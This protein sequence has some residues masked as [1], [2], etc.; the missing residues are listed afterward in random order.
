MFHIDLR[1][2]A[3][4]RIL[5]G[6]AVIGQLLTRLQDFA[7]FYTDQGIL[8]HQL[9]RELLGS[10][11]YWSLY[12][13]N[14]SPEWALFLWSLN[15]LFAIAVV[16]GCGTRFS[17]V[18][19]LILLWSLQ[20]RNV[21]VLTAGDILL[22]LLLIWM[23]LLPVNRFWSVDAWMRWCPRPHYLVENSWATTGIMLQLAAIYFFAG[24]AKLNEYWFSGEAL[25]YS[26]QLEMFASSWGRQLLNWPWPMKIATWVTLVIEIAAPVLL[27]SPWRTQYLRGF[28]M[29]L[30]WLLHASVWLTMS[31]GWFSPVAMIAWLIFVP[32]ELWGRLGL[33][34]SFSRLE[35]PAGGVKNNKFVD[36][37]G[38]LLILHLMLLNSTAAL[39]KTGLIAVYHQFSVATMTIQEFR[40][41]AQPP[42]YSP[43]MEYRA[44][45]VNGNRVDLFSK[46]FR[47]AQ[48]PPARLGFSELKHHAWRRYH[49][50]LIP[51]PETPIASGGQPLVDRARSQLLQYHVD[52]WNE[53]HDDAEQ[54]QNAELY[55]WIRP[56]TAARTNQPAEPQFWARY[57]RH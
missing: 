46:R 6:I 50:S 21:Y 48:A 49:A 57:Q 4:L 1:S 32:T 10:S 33:E 3:L 16:C 27:F 12:W 26:M 34:L 17:L 28:L 54:V 7:A 55:C 5:V 29:G 9:A 20:V 35:M 51:L 38:F 56:L 36:G 40:M 19:C 11:S 44:E 30:F 22:R 2:L 53:Q 13:L 47:A 23:V 18:A 24:I 52:R 42:L 39:S 45:L 31:V 14:S 25:S 37:L 8:P 15:L 43:T 41:F